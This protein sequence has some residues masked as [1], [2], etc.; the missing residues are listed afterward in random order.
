MERRLGSVEDYGIEPAKIRVVGFG[1]NSPRRQVERDWS[2]PRFVF[3]GID[4]ERKRGPAVL[5][6]FAT[7]RERHPEATLDLIGG[8]PP[9]DAPGVTGHGVLSLDSAEGR[10]RH[11][12]V[13]SP[14]HLPRDALQVRAVRDRLHRGG[15]RRHTQHRHDTNGGA[16]DAIGDGGVLVD[17]SRLQDLCQAMLGLCDP[18]AARALGERAFAHSAGFSWQAV[19]E[20]VLSALVLD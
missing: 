19:A 8:H 10:R 4:W 9:L 12:E 7:V 16:A 18:Q 20:R 15:G 17:P 6:A 13:L 1:S 5:E 3:I 14:R 2:V 11:A